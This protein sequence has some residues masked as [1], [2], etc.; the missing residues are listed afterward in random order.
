MVAPRVAVVAV[1]EA[2]VGSVTDG[3]S[4]TLTMFDEGVMVKPVA[5]PTTVMLP[6][7]LN[8]MSLKRAGS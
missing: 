1:K 2:E 6:A 3:T 4:I 8:V 7:V 5:D